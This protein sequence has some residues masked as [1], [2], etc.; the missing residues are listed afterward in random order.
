MNELNDFRYEPSLNENTRV[1]LNK[2]GHPEDSHFGIILC[3][4]QNP[5]SRSE[6]QWYDVRFDSG[7][8]GRFLE[9]YLTAIPYVAVENQLEGSQI[10]V[11]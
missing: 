3:A 9:R 6:N 1:R 7:T 4:L 5:S 10:S 2:E 11:A 8:M